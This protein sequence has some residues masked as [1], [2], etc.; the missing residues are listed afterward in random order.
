MKNIF[1]SVLG[2]LSLT[3]FASEQFN[4]YLNKNEQSMRN[5]EAQLTY[6]KKDLC[7]TTHILDKCHLEGLELSVNVP[8]YKDTLFVFARYADI[9]TRGATRV[10]GKPFYETIEAEIGVGV[11]YDISETLNLISTI[12][13]NSA[14]DTEW[15]DPQSGGTDYWYEG[16]LS[17]TASI[18]Q[19]NYNGGL[20]LSL[21]LK[22]QIT[23]N[24]A[25]CAGYI[26][27]HSQ[28][29]ANSQHHGFKSLKPRMKVGHIEICGEIQLSDDLYLVTSIK[30]MVK[31]PS[32]ENSNEF[33]IFNPQK[34]GSSPDYSIGFKYIFR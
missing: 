29:S 24:I 16:D 5:I 1:I 17:G 4:D 28:N 6:I 8:I 19:P 15:W 21:H 3:G 30:K 33:D 22:K 7:Y 31:K 23:E 12:S 2:L 9:E 13:Y 25:V 26:Q 10:D 27:D 18:E 14:S 20:K 34:Q 32:A 11:D